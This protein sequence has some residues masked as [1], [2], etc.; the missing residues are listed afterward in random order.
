M[1]IRD[2]LVSFFIGISVAIVDVMFLGLVSKLDRIF[3][4]ECAPAHWTYMPKYWTEY[5]KKEY[6]EEKNAKKVSRQINLH[7][8]LEFNITNS[9]Y[10]TNKNWLMSSFLIFGAFGFFYP[11]MRVIDLYDLN[12][13]NI[14]RVCNCCAKF[15]R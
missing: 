13:N 8:S 1:G 12:L 3:R 9:V 11:K 6:G 2:I 7:N 4:G 10:A 5:T 14:Y 15:R